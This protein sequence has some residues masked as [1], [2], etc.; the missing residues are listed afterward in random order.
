MSPIHPVKT[1][2][3]VKDVTENAVAAR[4]WEKYCGNDAFMDIFMCLHF[5]EELGIHPWSRARLLLAWKSEQAHNERITKEEF[6][7]GIQSVGCP[8]DIV[9]LRKECAALQLPQYYLFPQF[10][11]YVF[12][13][14][15]S[16]IGNKDRQTL[17]ANLARYLWTVVMPVTKADAWFYDWLKFLVDAPIVTITWKDW[18]QFLHFFINWRKM[19][20]GEYLRVHRERGNLLDQFFVYCNI[21]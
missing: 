9:N 8:P 5:L 14:A 13:F 19:G 7:R 10:Y 6:F 15:V 21:L 3:P 4:L 17:D 18:I 20:F 1:S 2:S 16:S 12:Y 11:G